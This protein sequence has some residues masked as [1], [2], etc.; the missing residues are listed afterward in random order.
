M[1]RDGW[2]APNT[3]DLARLAMIDGDKDVKSFTAKF[4]VPMAVVF[5][6]PRNA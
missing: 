5:T 3:S 2:R 6:L 1:P 4:R